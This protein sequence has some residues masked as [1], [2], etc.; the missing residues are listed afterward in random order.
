LQWFILK[1]DVLCLKA[2]GSSESALLVI[3]QRGYLLMS[4]VVML[5][6]LSSGYSPTLAALYALGTLVLTQI[7][8]E[9]KR[10]SDFFA[11]CLK[12]M[13]DAPR[14]I[15]Q[16]T[17]ASAV[18]GIIV[19]VVTQ[20]G[21]GL[22]MSSMV[23]NFSHGYLS[24]LLVLTMFCGIIL[25]MGMPTPAAY[26]ILAVLLAPGL[27]DVG[28]P[29]LAAHLFVMYC[30]GI[31]AITPPVALAS[32][33]AAAIANADP[34]KTSLTALRLG[35]A[36]FIIP[37]IFVFSPA[38]LGIGPVSQMI[39]DTAAA[40][41]GVLALAAALIGWLFIVMNIFL[42]LT[43][44]TGAI[45]MIMPGLLGDSL[46]LALIMGVTVFCWSRRRLVSGQESS[47]LPG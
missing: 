18:G 19:G 2:E 45:M 15:A 11:N 6:V 7:I 41:I 39:V 17:I 1:H 22:R 25:G 31:S 23:L 20:T 26:I 44:F 5:V 4:V 9:P 29:D 13:D 37:F 47:V 34:W 40:F 42:R 35:L 16:I 36:S 46:G 12:A 10:R 8:F 27:I 21:L 14:V 43:L 32:Y 28:V 33:A 30:A 3:K 24:L 38:L